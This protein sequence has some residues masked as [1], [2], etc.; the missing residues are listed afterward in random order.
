[1]AE[2]Q[3]NYGNWVRKRILLVLGI[4]TL[5]VGALELV[6]A[7]VVYHVVVTI[8]FA[9]L[10]LTFLFPL[11]AYFMFSENGGRFQAQLYGCIVQRLGT[12]RTGKYLD[13]GSGNGVL[14]VSL[15]MHNPK[16]E[17]VGVDF[18]GPDW[19]YSKA[20]CEQNARLAN[21]TERVQFQQ[22]D[23]AS[24]QFAAATFDGAVSNLTFHEVRSVANKRKVLEEALRVIKPRGSFTF[25]DYF[26]ESRYYGAPVEFRDYLAKLGL[27]EVR[28]TPLHEVLPVPVLLR[29]PKIFGKVAVLSGRK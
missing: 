10:L 6:P 8:I 7:G 9:L 3:L 26:L 29:H 13:I 17:V 27:A 25:V 19:E 5:A 23:A 15:A 21:V 14:T 11:Y 22:G 24:L 18:W 28:F 12:D 20:N 16:A 2:P 4:A 1:M